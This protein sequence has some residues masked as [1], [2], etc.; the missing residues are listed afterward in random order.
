LCVQG[1]AQ[2]LPRFLLRKLDVLAV[3]GDN[4]EAI[5]WA[6]RTAIE[7]G[8][9]L[10]ESVVYPEGWLAYLRRYNL[11][12]PAAVCPACNLS[13]IEWK[14]RTQRHGC[15]IDRTLKPGTV[16]TNALRGPGCRTSSCP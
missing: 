10:I 5:I 1:L 16:S 8:I 4:I 7:Y 11:T 9:P 3:A 6:A 14:S 12:D 2:D 15:S 13:D